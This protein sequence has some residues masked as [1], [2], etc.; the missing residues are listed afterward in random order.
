M[1]LMNQKILN[2]DVGVNLEDNSIVLRYEKYLQCR[3]YTQ[4]WCI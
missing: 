3:E 1:I 4:Y 2:N